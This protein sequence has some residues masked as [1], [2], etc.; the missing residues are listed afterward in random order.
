MFAPRTILSA[1]ALAAAVNAIPTSVDQTSVVPTSVVPASA[2]VPTAASTPAP[3]NLH[4]HSFEVYDPPITSPRAGDV[5]TAGQNQTVTW[6]VSKIGSDGH[7]TTASLLLGHREPGTLNE[8]LDI[9]AYLGL[10]TYIMQC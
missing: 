10:P 9:S 2:A 4:P 7:N 5:W 1:L 3:A 6:D 8:Y